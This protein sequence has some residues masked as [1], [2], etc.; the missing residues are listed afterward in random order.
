MYSKRDNQ[1]QFSLVIERRKKYETFIFA[2]RRNNGEG[3]F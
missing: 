3:K 2:K 1:E